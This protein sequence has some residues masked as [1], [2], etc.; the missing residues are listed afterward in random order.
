MQSQVRKVT[1]GK[2]R[3]IGL[4]WPD[5]KVR[6]QERQLPLL[7]MLVLLIDRRHRA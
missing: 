4:S 3:K 5:H 7:L 2:M 6:W 1:K